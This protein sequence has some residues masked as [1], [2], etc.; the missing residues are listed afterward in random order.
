MALANV[1]RKGSP[2][3]AVLMALGL[4][5]A[6]L[7]ALT[8]IDANLRAQLVRVAAGETPSF[9]F[10]DVRSADADRFRA[11][12]ETEAPAGR[13]VAV[14]MLRGRITR[15]NDVPAEQIKAPE[16]AS[17][18]LDGDRGITFAD[19]TPKNATLTEGQWWSADY[20]GPPLVS[21][22]AEVAKGLGLKL[23]DKVEVNVLG[24]PVKATIANFRKV[25]WRSFAINFVMVFS[26]DAFK[27]APY[28]D[29]VSLAFDGA[30]PDD[31]KL[32]RAV[33]KAFPTVVS[34]PVREAI[35][36]IDGLVANLALAIRLTSLLAL[37]AAVFVLAGA[38]AADRRARAREG[39]IL[40][41]L[42][43]TRGFM[44]GAAAREYAFIGG[45]SALVGGAWD[46]RSPLWS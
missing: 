36:T 33:A 20:S 6:V 26:P 37:F 38:L 18:A 3:P 15:L 39:A 45:A 22:E 34:I 2:A 21:F 46:R 9:Y 17:W 40:K 43:A 35:A 23:G 10:L 25:D 28:S 11:F 30:P 12:L 31:S 16:S 44:I 27:G 29:L 14:P 41:T 1:A 13:I 24:R 32:T 42:G 19:A 5:F 4:G 8:L 7:T